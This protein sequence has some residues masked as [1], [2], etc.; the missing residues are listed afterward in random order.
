[1]RNQPSMLLFCE[2]VSSIRSCVESAGCRKLEKTGIPPWLSRL[3]LATIFTV[4]KAQE[5]ACDI[6]TP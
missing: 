1:M 2:T 3:Q 6:Q 5:A 4:S